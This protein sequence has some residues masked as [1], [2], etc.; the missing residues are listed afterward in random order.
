MNTGTE[1]RNS[2]EMYEDGTESMVN[3]LITSNPTIL[4]S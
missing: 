4:P 1:T 3:I 2:K